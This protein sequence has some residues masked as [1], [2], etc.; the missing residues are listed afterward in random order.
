MEIATYLRNKRNHTAR[1]LGVWVNLSDPIH[2]TQDEAKEVINGVPLCNEISDRDGLA[3]ST[4]HFEHV[5]F[6]SL[7]RFLDIMG[8]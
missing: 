4:L 7:E 2:C 5:C 3:T 6:G 1:N 8:T